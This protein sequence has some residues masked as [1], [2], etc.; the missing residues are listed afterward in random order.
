LELNAIQ[1]DKKIEG[2]AGF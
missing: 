1:K 2:R